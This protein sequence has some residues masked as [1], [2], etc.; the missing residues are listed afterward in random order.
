VAFNQE[1]YDFVARNLSNPQ[2]IADKMA[3]YGVD[4]ST[5]SGYIGIPASDINAYFNNAGISFGPKTISMPDMGSITT[6]QEEAERLLAQEQEAQAAADQAARD[7]AIREEAQRSETAR[8]AAEQAEREEAARQE[9]ARIEA[10]RLEAEKTERDRIEAERAQQE[11]ERNEALRQEA[12]NNAVRAAIQNGFTVDELRAIAKDMGLPESMVDQAFTTMVGSKANADI[13]KEVTALA[14]GK[15]IGFDKIVEYAD[16][17][18]LP[19][20]TV[21]DALK[22]TFKDTTSQQIVDAMVYEKDRQEFSAIGRDITQDGKT[23]RV[24]DLGD[25]IATAIKRGIDPANL[26]KFYGK[27]EAEFKTLVNTNLTQI[28]DTVRRAGIDSAQ[29]LSDLLGI[30]KGL[31]STAIKDLDIKTGLSRLTDS[32]GAIPLDKALEYAAQNKLSNDQLASYLGI[33]PDVITKYQTDTA[34][35][36]GLNRLADDKGQVAFDKAIQFASDNNLTIDQLAGYL[37]IEPGQITQ[38]QTDTRVRSGLDVAAGEDKQLNYD[39]II[40]FAADNKM[41]L[42]EVVNYIGTPESRKDLLSGIQSYVTAKEADAKLTGPER[43]AS[44]L[45]QITKDGTAAGVWDKNQ[46]WAHHSEKMVDYLSGYGITDLNQVGTRIETRNLPPTGQVTPGE[47][48]RATEGEQAANYVVY[49]DKVT[50]K[51]LQAVPQSDNGGMWRFGSEGKGKGSTGYFLGPT[52]GGGAGIT[53]NWEEKYGAKEYALPLALAAA[54]AAPYLLPELIGAAGAAVDVGAAAVGTAASTTAVAS[55]A[56]GLTGM[57]MSAGIPAAIAGPTATAIVRGTYQGLVNE[58][59]GG[60]FGKG[61]VSGVAPVISNMVT[62]E[63]FDTLYNQMGEDGRAVFTKDQSVIAA[64]AVG[65]ALNQLIVNGDIDLK[66]VLTTTASPYVVQALVDAS[67]KTLTPAQAKFIT[68]TVFS[69]AKNITDMANNPLAVMNFVQNNAKLIDELASGVSTSNKITLSG[70]TDEQQRSLAE[71]SEPGSDISQLAANTVTVIAGSDTAMGAEGIDAISGTP[72]VEVVGKNLP[73]VNDLLTLENATPVYG[74][75]ATNVM[76]GTPSVT[77]QSTRPIDQQ[78][79]LDVNTFIPGANVVTEAEPVVVGAKSDLDDKQKTTI[80]SEYQT[81][82]T[83]GPPVTVISTPIV[84]EP[85]LDISTL[86]PDINVD[87][88]GI[89]VGGKPEVVVTSTKLVDT[90]DPLDMP[91][92]TPEVT[93]ATTTPPV[94]T[95]TPPIT[96]TLPDITIPP[97]TFE[98][99]IPA[100][101]VTGPTTVTDDTMVYQYPTVGGPELPTYYG[102]PY[103]NYLRPFDPYLPMGLGALMEAMYAQEQGNGGNQSLQNAGAQVKVP[104]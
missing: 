27:T 53:S 4:V 54:F 5:L 43:L 91:P 11:A 96:T 71:V 22:S 61:F 15:P 7:A 90:P 45:N 39:E 1:V 34:I 46:G 65:S 103:P 80:D 102:M 75:G 77:V 85:V 79:F 58:A 42:S 8:L 44:Q 76:A 31:T 97:I 56:T 73:T 59:A 74:L 89:L 30:D 69:G 17:A 32:K 47:D 26:A 63:V 55:G 67:D 25:A 62:K 21:A 51:E 84:D 14:G 99:G 92:V 20:A 24:V 72:T 3:E 82:E 100:T 35:T 83:S 36:T 29:G 33:K 37:G 13:I 28:A 48:F 81:T 94:T 78:T 50:G 104:T 87:K 60:D 19:Y 49:Y 86:I 12:L 70:L 16:K 88:G 18:K 10:A 9:A 101:K 95:V 6:A 64:R 57:L 98:P 23:V 40:K 93:P 2:L 52:Q 38:Y 41:D 66:N 68:Q